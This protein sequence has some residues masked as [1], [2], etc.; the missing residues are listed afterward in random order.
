ME[1]IL[2]EKHAYS[3]KRAVV[4]GS[5]NWPG[6]KLYTTPLVESWAER[7]GSGYDFNMNRGGYYFPI[8]LA[9]L[10]GE[11]VRSALRNADVKAALGGVRDLL[12]KKIGGC[13]QVLL[14]PECHEDGVLD[15]A[16]C[17]VDISVS[18]NKEVKLPLMI[19]L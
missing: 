7:H 19:L 18:E 16:D 13:R 14:I 17:N 15:C 10:N 4:L 9:L 12:V 2:L 3:R 5:P 11:I 1:L 6:F 8:L